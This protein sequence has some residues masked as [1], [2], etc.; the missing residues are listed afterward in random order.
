M[1]LLPIEAYKELNQ[2]EISENNSFSSKVNDNIGDG[3][4]TNSNDQLKKK[5]RKSYSL[6]KKAE[7]IDRFFISKAQNKNLSLTA[8][9]EEVG[10]EKS[11]ISKWI[12]DKNKIFEKAYLKKNENKVEK[13]EDIHG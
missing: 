13:S 8:Y 9:A 12:Q 6:A 1:F 5:N 2:Q 11:M 10:V 4:S 3:L 7:I